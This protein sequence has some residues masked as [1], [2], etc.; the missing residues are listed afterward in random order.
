MIKLQITVKTPSKKW[1]SIAKTDENWSASKVGRQVFKNGKIYFT[2]LILTNVS[3]H[4]RMTLIKGFIRYMHKQKVTKLESR[5][6]H[7]PKSD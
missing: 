7:F 4:F 3:I 5:K 2:S 6:L 1:M